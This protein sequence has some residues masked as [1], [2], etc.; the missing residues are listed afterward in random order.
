MQNHLYLL[1]SFRGKNPSGLSK[2]DSFPSSATSFTVESAT[3]WQ[4]DIL[5]LSQ[6]A[7]DKTG[8]KPTPDR[9]SRVLSLGKFLE[10]EK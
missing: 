2:S 8:W 10:N 5:G 9:Q 4:T 1:Q 7:Q 3:I 6:V